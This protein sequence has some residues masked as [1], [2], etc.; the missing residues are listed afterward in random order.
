MRQEDEKMY[1]IPN[2]KRAKQSS[3]RLYEGL[4][5]A[6]KRKSLIDIAVTDITK[7]TSVS[8]ATFYRLFDNPSDILLY[9]CDILMKEAIDKAQGLI[10]SSLQEC[11]TSYISSLMESK[12]LLIALIDNNR[13]DIL[14]Y[15][16][17]SYIKD[18]EKTFLEGRGLSEKQERFLAS[19]LVGIMPSI[20]KGWLLEQNKSAQEILVEVKEGISIMK[21]L[22]DN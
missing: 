7:E 17:E 11:F 18:I 12:E 10:G 16:H 8:R 19:M 6:L 21:E 22:F 14:S 15:S 4:I 13:M 3:E 9:K 2:D 1:H 5:K 20:F